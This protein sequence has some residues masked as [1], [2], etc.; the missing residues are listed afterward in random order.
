MKNPRLEELQTIARYCITKSPG[1][2]AIALWVPYHVDNDDSYVAY[3]DGKKI[4]IGNKFWD[5]EPLERAFIFVHEIMHV[6]LRHIPRAAKLAHR[7]SAHYH[8]WNIA[9]DAIIN[10][11]LS[12]MGW[13][14]TPK[15]GVKFEKILPEEM[16]QTHPPQSW[17]VEALYL[18][19]LKQMGL[20]NS[21]EG[22]EEWVRDWMKKNG[23]D[24]DNLDLQPAPGQ[25][26]G[27][28]SED[29]ASRIWASR[30]MRA[31]AGDRAGGLL[32]QLKNDF[33]VAKTPWPQILRAFLQDAV[34][35]RSTENWSRPGRRMLATD[36]EIF[37]P[38]TQREKGIRKI[39][40][41]VDTSGS[42][43]DEI[44]KRFATEI[45]Q[46]QNRSGCEIYL[47]SADADVQTEQIV[48]NDGKPFLEKFKSGAILFKGGGGTAFGPAI[49]K[50]NLSSATIGMYLTDMQGDFGSNPPK[51]PFLW[52]STYPNQDAPFGKVIYLDPIDL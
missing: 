10:N 2:A 43:N 7:S 25:T 16:L 23:I 37:E 33:P 18:E 27:D 48:K 35:P 14:Q 45:E 49:D 42:I 46:I 41:A 40:I 50:I 32:R 8:V 5:Y 17:G 31:Q 26:S 21:G 28:L 9:A 11:A 3:T 13:L 47:I 20:P 19:L 6:A 24:P 1:F 52:C 30:L 4:V 29:V 51:M 44:L 15:D 39:A 12:Q 38:A 22:L 36:S 34:M